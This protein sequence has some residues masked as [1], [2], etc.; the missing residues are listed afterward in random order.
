MSAPIC[1]DCGLPI[2]EPYRSVMLGGVVCHANWLVCVAALK[3]ALSS[4]E[5]D[6]DRYRGV[7]VALRD[8]NRAVFEAREAQMQAREAATEAA[9]AGISLAK[10]QPLLDA[11]NRSYGAIYVANGAYDR[12]SDAAIAAVEEG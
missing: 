10:Y 9:S 6:R 1:T 12:A 5:S 11:V 2:A 4:A 8:A 3:S 7:L